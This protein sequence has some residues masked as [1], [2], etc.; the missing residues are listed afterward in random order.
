MK[1]DERIDL[2]I[3]RSG[4]FAKPI[5]TEIRK[6]I[7]DLCPEIEETMKWSFPNFMLGKRILCSI[8]AFKNH[9]SFGFWLSSMMQTVDSKRDGMGDMGK[10]TR[11]EDLPTMENFKLMLYEAVE[12]TKAGKTI[13]KKQTSATSFNKSEELLLALKDDPKAYEIFNKFSMSHQKEYHEWILEAKTEAT[14]NKR[15]LQAVEWIGEGKSRNW[16]YMKC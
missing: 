12:L 1:T 7:H 2:Y 9:C 6:R 3:E 16:K 5:L 14:I 13:P 4:D 15:I 10:I 11:L 8:A